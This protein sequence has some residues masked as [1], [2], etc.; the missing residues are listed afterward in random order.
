VTDD[1]YTTSGIGAIARFHPDAAAMECYN[2]TT[3][4]ERWCT[5]N[6]GTHDYLKLIPG[7]GGTNEGT[8]EWVATKELANPTM[9]RNS[10]GAEVADG[11][12][13]FTAKVDQLVFFLNLAEKTYVQ[14]STICGKFTQQPDQIAYLGKTL[15]FAN[16]G[17]YPNGVYGWHKKGGFFKV[18]VSPDYNTETSGIAFSPDKKYMYVAWQSVGVW[19]FWREDGYGFDANPADIVYENCPEWQIKGTKK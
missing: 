3:K 9:Y 16:D 8:F 13:T 1:S 18:V 17:T 5:L 10:E 6:S 4:A 7:T 14:Y 19:Q 12:L 11:I 15:Y 2:K